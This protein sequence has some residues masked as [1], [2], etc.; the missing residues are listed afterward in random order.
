MKCKNCGKEMQ[1]MGSISI[2]ADR[3][4]KYVCEC[5]N[6]KIGKSTLVS[7]FGDE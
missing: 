2:G 6:V 5:G 7:F 4:E 3:K 1:Y